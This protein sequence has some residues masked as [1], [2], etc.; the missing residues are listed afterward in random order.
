MCSLTAGL[1]FEECQGKSL[2][3]IIDSERGAR[4]RL[5]CLGTLSPEAQTQAH[6]GSFFVTVCTL[7]CK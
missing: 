7:S 6:G 2:S 4:G 1:H 5:A 3:W